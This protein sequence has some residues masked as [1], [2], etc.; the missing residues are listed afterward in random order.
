MMANYFDFFKTMTQLFN[1]STHYKLDKAYLNECFEQTIVEKTF[2]QA[3]QKS[4]LFVAFGMFLLMATALNKYLSSFMVALGIVEALSVRFQQPWWVARQLLGRSGNSQVE[5][6][7]DDN[8]IAINS[9]Y[10]KLQYQWSEIE[11]LER[12][13]KGFVLTIAGARQYISAST[14][15]EDAI[16]FMLARI[17]TP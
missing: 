3:Y 14:L 5:L 7:V 8:G 2:F 16:A 13:E 12:T 9:A 10:L 11:H 17:E 6:S 1:Y 4:F 15:S